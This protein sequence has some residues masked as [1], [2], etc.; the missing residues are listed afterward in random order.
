MMREYTNMLLE[1]SKLGD[2]EMVINS[3]MWRP[4]D[5]QYQDGDATLIKTELG[6]EPKFSIRDTIHDL[7][8]FWY[9]KLK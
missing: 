4:I 1:F 9:N 7:L 2:V 8:V 6:W 3:K 5:I